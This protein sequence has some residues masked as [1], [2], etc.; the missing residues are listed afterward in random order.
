MRNFGL[1][2]EGK[3][4]IIITGSLGHISKPLT[5]E[6]VEKG[7]SVTVISSKPEKEKDI[8]ALGAKAAIGSLEDVPFLTKTF[9]GA[10]IVYLMEPPVHFLNPTADPE[11]QWGGIAERYVQAIQQSGIKKVIHLSSIGAH[12]DKGNGMLSAHYYVENI[13]KQLPSNVSIK[14]MRPVGFYYNMFAFV[15]SIKAQGV[16]VQNYGGDEKEPWVSPLDIA[17][18]IAEEIEKPF[19]GREVRY[20]ASDEVSP[21]EVA[22]IL[23]EAIGKPDLKWLVISDE[24][25]KEGLI[26]AGFSLKSAEGFVGMNAGRINGVLYEDYDHR[27]PV[28]GKV[29]LRDFAKDFADAFF[30]S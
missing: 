3:M 29:K 21:N 14:F 13:L 24:Q 6:L 12:T 26:S 8:E 10:D 4:K 18:V 7:H 9:T 16:I 19:A 22:E 20:I 25:F 17:A 27:R 5:K 28:L 11:K 2:K 23:G 30:K 1:T 15:P